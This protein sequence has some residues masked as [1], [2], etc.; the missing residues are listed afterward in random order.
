MLELIYILE[1]LR[2][3]SKD[4]HYNFTGVDFK[5]LHEWADEIAEP[6]GG[7]IDEIKEQYILYR[8]QEV[9]SSVE[10]MKNA[11]NYVPESVPKDNKGLLRNLRAIINM[12][13][14][15]IE[16]AAPNTTQGTGDLLGRIGSHLQKHSGLLHLALGD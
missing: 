10:I 12:A 5:P 3:Y 11:F 6:L 1:A 7:W 13:I 8:L 15:Q 2:L 14:K 4:C 9:P 16:K